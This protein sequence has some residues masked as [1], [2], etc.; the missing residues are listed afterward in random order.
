MRKILYL[1]GQLN[2]LDI[3]WMLANGRKEKVPRGT[4][5]IHEGKPVE[6]LYIVLVGTVEVSGSGLDKANP[7]R[8]GC[9]E[10]VGEVSFVDSRPPMANVTAGED[11][12]VLAIPRARLAAKLAADS[13]FAARF[14]R[15]LAIFLAHRLRST[16]RRLGYS[17]GQPLRE[18][19]EYEDELGEEVLDNLHMAGTRFDHV[20]QR[21][22]AD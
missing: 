1:L 12:T 20:L 4:V 13:D 18:D 16:T 2:D 7:I 21:L 6:A 3:A 11:T 5:L 14:Y 10:V 15:S 9:G 22:L 17:H 19:Q 8:L